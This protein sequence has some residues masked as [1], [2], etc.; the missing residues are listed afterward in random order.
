MS[1]ARHIPGHAAPAP[2]IAIYNPNVK[3]SES[4]E[5]EDPA[6]QA[7]LGPDPQ[8]RK[9]PGGGREKGD[10]EQIQER[11]PLADLLYLRCELR[12]S[13]RRAYRARI[14]HPV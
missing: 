14:A 13:V 10:I 6:A 8:W 5:E 12:V 3:Y 2:A 11:S 9:M 4:T 1:I 7:G